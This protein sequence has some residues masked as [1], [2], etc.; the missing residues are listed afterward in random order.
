MIARPM[1]KS[2]WVEVGPAVSA[3]RKKKQRQGFTLLE[4]L[5][6]LV[7]LVSAVTVLWGSFAQI[8]KAT[9]KAERMLDGLH[10]GDFAIEQLVQALRSA[11]F[12]ESAPKNYGFWLDDKQAGGVDAD[13]LSWVTSSDA[14]IP[15]NS[16]LR[17]GLHRIYVSI[18][19]DEE[20]EPGL[21]ASAYPHLLDPEDDDVEEIEPWL[22]SKE[23]IGINCRVYDKTGKSWDED[24]D[25]ELDSLPRFVELTLYLRPS[26]PTEEPLEVKRVVDIPLAIQAERI[27]RE[28]VGA[29]EEELPADGDFEEG[30]VPPGQGGLGSP[31]AFRRGNNQRGGAS[32][33]GLT[34]GEEDFEEDVVAPR[35]NRR[36]PRGNPTRSPA[37][38]STSSPGLFP[39]TG[40][41]GGFTR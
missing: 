22:V 21:A 4:L 7:V 24:W 32:G 29:A 34:P 30:A 2:L 38:D 37:G 39:G 18:E 36:A 27:R 13:I 35:N 17:H 12:F 31:G 6:A 15:P 20:G 1:I 23:I 41:G 10:H 40:S 8:V 25:D 3:G 26:D 28:G 19:D 14:F 11:T 9:Q 5:V 33:T 16:P